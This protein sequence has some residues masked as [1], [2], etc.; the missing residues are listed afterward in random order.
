METL[1]GKER[2]V[3]RLAGETGKSCT[4]GREAAITRT[5]TKGYANEIV[6]AI[7]KTNSHKGGE[8]RERSVGRYES[9]AADARGG[10][11]GVDEVRASP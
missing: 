3:R 1:R 8:T 7:G 2:F 11:R 5:D 4:R 9:Y 10:N 6:R